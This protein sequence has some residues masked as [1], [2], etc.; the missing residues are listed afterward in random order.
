MSAQDP[1][2]AVAVLPGVPEA[3]DRARE[4]V[5]RLRGHRVLRRRSTEVTGE[6]VL[7]GARASAALEGADVPLA[8]FR[9]EQLWEAGDDAPRADR[10]IAQG[11]LRVTAELGPLAQSWGQAPLQVIA[12]LHALAAVGTVPERWLGRPRDDDVE[13]VEVGGGDGLDG[14]PGAPPGASE[15]SA[16][17]ATLARML[18]EARTGAPAVVVGAVVHGELLA[19]RPFVRGNGLVA[20]AAERLVLVSR[21]LDPKSVSAPEVGHAELGSEP[22]LAALRGYV[23]ATPD[24]IG[25]WVGHCA[26][27][28]VLGAREGLAVCEALARG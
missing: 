7:R 24:G 21:G 2:A 20:R 10:L 19:L 8:L 22:Y 26:D 13:D 9:S 25:R 27:A 12:R 3:V 28:V 6:C 4:A 14:P 17:L 15:V 23:S 16:R 18:V 1:F 11:A 5:D